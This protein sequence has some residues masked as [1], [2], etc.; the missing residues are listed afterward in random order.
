MC[1]AILSGAKLCK[2]ILLMESY[3]PSKM[4]MQTK[5]EFVLQAQVMAVMDALDDHHHVQG[6]YANFDISDEI[7]AE[8]T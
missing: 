7:L 8:L 5:I 2:T 6:V 1:L 3:G 4:V